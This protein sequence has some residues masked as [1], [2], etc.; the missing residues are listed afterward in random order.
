MH[1][2]S[3]AAGSRS[4]SVPDVLPRDTFW[5]LAGAVV[6]AVVGLVV[7]RRVRGAWH[8]P[9]A[10]ALASAHIGAVLGVTLFPLRFGGD[11]FTVPYSSVQLVPLATIQ[12]LLGGSQSARQLGGNLALLA[13]MGLLVPIAWRAAR[14]FL[15]T[16]AWGALVSV[17]IEVLQFLFGMVTGEF[18]RVVDVDDVLLNVVGVVI[19]RLLFAIGW[20][21]WRRFTRRAPRAP[22]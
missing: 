7:A 11:P 8:R 5:L 13:P 6:G 15:R 9:V 16:V 17:S 10:V 20:P 21:L 22:D 19:G 2:R 1:S 12:L 4:C 14:P 18:Y 3:S